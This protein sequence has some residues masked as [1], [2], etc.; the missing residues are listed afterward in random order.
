MINFYY[1][2]IRD[3]FEYNKLPYFNIDEI[4]EIIPQIQYESDGSR[5]GNWFSDILE[6][7][8]L[9]Q[10]DIF[11]QKFYDGGFSSY[12]KF[13]VGT[14]KI[15]SKELK[16]DVINYKKKDKSVFTLQYVDDEV[17]IIICNSEDSEQ[18]IKIVNVVQIISNIDL[19][20][21]KL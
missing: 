12:S 18:L 13:E 19:N 5:M 8:S 20:F 17:D 4:V 7:A 21:K 1:K 11:F 3:V 15:N 14:Y 9:L 6:Y 16:N 2:T 10:R